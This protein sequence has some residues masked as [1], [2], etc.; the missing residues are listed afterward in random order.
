MTARRCYG[1]LAGMT[2][3][4]KSDRRSRARLD[5]ERC[6]RRL[7]PL[8]RMR[9]RKSLIDRVGDIGAVHSAPRHAWV[10]P[11]VTTAAQ[12]SRSLRFAP[13]E[14]LPL[15]WRTSSVASTEF[16]V[17]MTSTPQ[18]WSRSSTRS[19]APGQP[20]D[21]SGHDRD[22][23]RQRISEHHALMRLPVTPPAHAEPCPPPVTTAPRHAPSPPLCGSPRPEALRRRARRAD[24]SNT[25]R[26]ALICLVIWAPL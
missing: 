1:R 24:Q 14:T 2:T 12:S 25:T 7:P 3:V 5:D 10:G 20:I 21:G 17:P 15:V 13:S 6:V 26:T 22:E 4:A 16:G 8:Q 23:G 11:T 19:P 9:R 18:S